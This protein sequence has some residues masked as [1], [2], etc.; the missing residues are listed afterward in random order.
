MR[1]IITNKQNGIY[2]R[3]VPRMSLSDKEMSHRRNMHTDSSNFGS[4]WRHTGVLRLL[5]ILPPHLFCSRDGVQSGIASEQRSLSEVSQ[6]LTNPVSNVCQCH[7]FDTYF[8]DGDLNKGGSQSAKNDLSAF[9]VP[10][11]GKAGIS[12]NSSPVPTYL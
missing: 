5:M 7:E 6:E 11:Y 9:A 1:Q 2:N 3:T 10:S 8:L 4:E 12:G